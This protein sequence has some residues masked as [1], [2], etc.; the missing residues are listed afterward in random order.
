ML[1]KL[2]ECGDLKKLSYNELDILSEEI[3]QRICDVV[4]KN[5]GHLASNLGIV[6]TTIALHKVYDF[7]KD[8]IVFDVGHQCYAH[9]ILTGRND[10]FETIRK[11]DGISGFTNRF[12]SEYDSFTA[13]HSGS[14]ISSCL[15]IA[16]A[17]KLL[18][19]DSYCVAVVGDGSFTN[20]M[21]YEA[22]NNCLEKGLRMTIVLNDNEMSIS[23]NVGNLAKY[24]QKYSTTKGYFRFKS[25]LKNTVIRIPGIGEKLVRV[26]RVIKNALKRLFLPNN[27]FFTSMG[28]KYIGPVDGHDI[29]KLVDVFTEAK[30]SDKCCIV[31]VKT[32]KGMG[33][34]KA[35][36]HPESYH[37]VSKFDMDMGVCAVAKPSFS[38]AFGQMMT[39][40]A[41]KDQKLV[42]LTAAMCEGTGLLDFSK[43]YPERFFDVGI[44]EE[45]EI[46]FAAGLSAGGMKPVCAIYSTFAQRVYDQVMHD[47]SVQQLGITI[48]VDRAGFVPDD[49]ITHQGLFD[50]SLLSSIPGCNIYSPETYDEMQKCFDTA[51]ESNSIDV[52]RYSKG[53]QIIYDR[54]AFVYNKNYSFSYCAGDE[55]DDVVIVTY[56]R[57]TRK[58]VGAKYILGGKCKIKIIKL[59]KCYPLDDEIVECIGNPKLVY[60]LEEGVLSGGVGEKLASKLCGKYNG[61]IVINAVPNVHAFHASVE[62]LYDHFGMSEEKIA[63]EIEK[64]ICGGIVK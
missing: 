54:T 62:E 17:N 22:I 18:G 12:E 37:S 33:Y 26:F 61:K 47:V 41:A 25:R 36:E 43:R 20:G 64:Y 31:L 21:I 16:K 42:C 40:Y 60:I 58:A 32:T 9:K 28:L 59:V 24:L 27:G 23:T 7:P 38:E 53:P 14:S 11:K 56:G 34:D 29:E 13:G 45:H 52:V 46:T 19:K 50:I 3:R 10:R 6:E 4:S 35:V 49:G 39:E 55:D 57:V 44:A 63:K 48:A 51:I 8:N 2:N 30:K 15:G 1:E 5:G